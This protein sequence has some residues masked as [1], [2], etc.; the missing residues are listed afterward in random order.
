[1]VIRPSDLSPPSGEA[2]IILSA[3]NLGDAP[4]G[5]PA[6]A[7]VLVATLP[8]GITVLHASGVAGY[9][10]AQ[11]APVECAIEAGRTV[12]CAFEGSLVPYDQIEIRIRVELQPGEGWTE[13]ENRF[14]V[15]GGGA[16]PVVLER[17]L[18]PADDDGPLGIE[19][20]ELRPEE[21]GGAIEAR[22]GSHP[23][24]VTTGMRLTQTS[25]ALP[26]A[27]P[28]DLRLRLPPGLLA[29]S[30]A[31]PR[32]S[33]TGF[34]QDVCPLNTVVGVGTFTVNDQSNLGVASLVAPIF[35]LERSLGGPARFG[36]LPLRVPVIIDAS[37]RADDYSAELRIGNIP[38]IVGFLG[39]TVTLWG[40][41]ADPRHDDA[42]GSDCLLAAREQ[43]EYQCHRLEATDPRAM[44]TMPTSCDGPS[45]SVGEVVPW[46][47]RSYPASVARAFPRMTGCG[48]LPF[49]PSA[50][51]TPTESSASSP[52]GLDLML[53]ARGVGLGSPEGLAESAVK[54][55]EAILPGG[56]TL[57]PSAANGLLSCDRAGFESAALHRDGCPDASKIGAVAIESSIFPEPLTGSVYLG[58]EAG[59]RF[60]GSLDLYIVA[61]NLTLGLLVKLRARLRLDPRTGRIAVVADELPPLPL[62]SLQLRFPPGPRA[63][64]ATPPECG[65]SVLETVF[66]P[67]ADPAATV[68]TPSPLTISSGPRGG[69]CP[70]AARPFH[71]F[72][73]AGTLNNAAALYSP[74]YVRLS[75]TDGDAE[76]AG[77][78]LAFPPGL[79]ARLAGVR[80][81]SP[82][83]LAAAAARSGAAEAAAPSCPAAAQIGRTLVGAGVGP[84]L[85]HV[86]GTLYLA[87]PYQGA[88]ISVAA[89]TAAQLGPFDLGTIVRRFP[90]G[91]ELRTGQA[92]IE[93]G[94]AQR[95]PSILNGVALH[96][97]DFRLYFDRQELTVNPTSCAPARL[98][99]FAYATDGNVGPLAERFQAA[100]C[101]GLRFKPSLSLRLSGGLRRN[102][103]PALRATIRA[104]AREARI[105][106][107]GFTLP[108]GELLDFHH[109]GNLCARGIPAASCPASSRIGYV[110]LWTP[111]LDDPLRGPIYLRVPVRGLPALVT[112]LRAGRVNVVLHGRAA[113]AAGRLQVLLR[114]LP[115]LPLTE[116]SIALDGGR[117]G[118]LVN[119]E[120]LCGAQRRAHAV[121]SAHSG[122]SRRLHPRIRLH[123]RC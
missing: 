54:G 57:N 48:R 68:E 69:S 62:S 55:V 31:V 1:M 77:L 17:R 10:Y 105:A 21:A 116:A 13:E 6:G 122:K 30:S 49:Q 25:E 65:A 70:T 80:T 4:A 3:L 56:F 22:A 53:G 111:L 82:A 28:K 87:G 79:A 63:L 120:A 104:G 43:T 102:G 16:P 32:C 5:G 119:S 34:H 61:H 42:R 103:H 50:T 36:S 106:A 41:P 84:V 18:A 40:V 24:Q 66:T 97:R 98:T 71:P 72:F 89:V 39:A 88:P 15:R 76:L 85:S 96:L 67:H 101:A 100:D 12:S 7:V 2:E 92:S 35:N 90:L 14:A 75:R 123:G 64:L 109:V 27:L 51:A 114:G 37:L 52:S 78:S 113:S 112:D 73:A 33:V 19:E 59:E 94:E 44:L 45:R 115:D 121:L 99:G 74:L 83:A 108:P 9:P 110:Q 29:D 81:C 91:I 58:G 118:L 11:A 117:R 107:A 8:Q 47:E 95:L 86:P 20:F 23:Y 38:Q 60:A 46:T 93:F 26:T